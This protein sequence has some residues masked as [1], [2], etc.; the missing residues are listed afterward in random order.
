M[1]KC[2]Q[3]VIAAKVVLEAPE[4]RCVVAQSCANFLFH[5]TVSYNLDLKKI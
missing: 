5:M 3:T 4:S 1:N 2:Q